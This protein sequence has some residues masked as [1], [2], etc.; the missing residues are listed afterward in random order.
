MLNSRQDKMQIEYLK[1]IIFLNKTSLHH[2]N[3]TYMAAAVIHVCIEHTINTVTVTAAM[4]TATVEIR[5]G[6]RK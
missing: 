5:F 2:R 6:A 4:S 3:S 1:Q